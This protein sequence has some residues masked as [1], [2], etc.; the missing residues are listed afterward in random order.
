[1]MSTRRAP[2]RPDHV[3]EEYRRRDSQVREH[4]SEGSFFRSLD[5]R[6]R[7]VGAVSVVERPVDKT[8]EHRKGSG[9]ESSA[10]CRADKRASIAFVQLYSGTFGRFPCEREILGQRGSNF[11][12]VGARARARAH[13]L[14]RQRELPRRSSI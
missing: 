5:D 13:S 2:S 4:P 10:T 3:L 12:R 11:Q 14:A 7:R 8:L 9:R 6:A 1:M